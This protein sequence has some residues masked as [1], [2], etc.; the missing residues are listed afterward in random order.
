ML[1]VWVCESV[2][3]CLLVHQS[4]NT[5]LPAV[6]CLLFVHQPS[7]LHTAALTFQFTRQSI[8]YDVPYKSHLCLFDLKYKYPQPSRLLSIDILTTP[9]EQLQQ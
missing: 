9:Q 1:L 6:L 4:L 8:R 5:I 7:P 3:A 2:K